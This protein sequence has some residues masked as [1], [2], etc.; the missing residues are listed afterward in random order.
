MVILLVSILASFAISRFPDS[1]AFSSVLLKQQLIAVTR[2]AQQTALSRSSV[3]TINLQISLNSGNWNMQVS[4]GGGNS[5]T[6]EFPRDNEEIY[7]SATNVAGACSSLTSVSTTAAN[8]IFDGDAN[9]SPASNFRLCIDGASVTE[10]CISA[11]GFIYDGSC[12]L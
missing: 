11:A 2:Q 4:G 5:Y 10:L 7:Y 12:L 3:G 1:Q 9:L 8:L 6:A